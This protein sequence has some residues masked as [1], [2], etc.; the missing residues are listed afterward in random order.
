MLKPQ[1]NCHNLRLMQS[2]VIYLESEHFQQ[3]KEISLHIDDEAN[4][5][6]GY[7]NSLALFALEKW[8]GAHIESKEISLYPQIEQEFFY[9]EIGDFKV[10]LLATEHL[11]DEVVNVPQ[12]VIENPEFTAHFYVVIEILEEE[13]EAIIRCLLRYDEIIDYCDQPRNNYYQL[14][15]A[16]FD[17]EPNHLL[18]YTQYLEPSSIPLPVA[19]VPE[20]STLSITKLSQWLQ[21][22]VDETWQ[23]IELLINPESY[24]ALSTRNVDYGAK[25][26][27]LVDLGL[28][29]D[30]QSLA[31]LVNISEAADD[32]LSVLIQLHPTAREKYLPPNLKLSL[33]SKAGKILQEV[34]SRNQDNYIQLRPFKGESGKHFSIVV[35]LLDVSVKEDFEL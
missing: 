12:I 27:K 24:L 10:C 18:F 11:L 13:A 7:L 16:V 21:G 20:V 5:W 14:P 22:V 26:G 28:Q 4:R 33:L 35:S 6:Q 32:K 8:L 19:S 25:K 31:L 3:A 2:M 17:D 30:K 15:L 23:A 1:I 9:L 29:L 34:S